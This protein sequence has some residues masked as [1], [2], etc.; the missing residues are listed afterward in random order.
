MNSGGDGSKSSDVLSVDLLA[1]VEPV[2]F[3]AKMSIGESFS[4]RSESDLY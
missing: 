2:G 1:F 3:V 4:G